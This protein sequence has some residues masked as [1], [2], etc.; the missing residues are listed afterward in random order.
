MSKVS[1]AGKDE[2]LQNLKPV[3]AAKWKEKPEQDKKKNGVISLA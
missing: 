3:L 2:E 1:S